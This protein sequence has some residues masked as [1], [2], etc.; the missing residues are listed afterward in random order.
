M[1]IIGKIKKLINVFVVTCSGVLNHRSNYISQTFEIS[2]F[3]R[4]NKNNITGFISNAIH[5]YNTR[6]NNRNFRCY[7]M[8][9]RV[10]EISILIMFYR[11][12]YFI[13]LDEGWRKIAN[14]PS[15]K[16]IFKF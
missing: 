14:E 5:F 2:S 11:Y 10:F 6:N 12:F 3:I 7:L 9:V 15:F 13:S 1:S 16:K 8:I 4:F